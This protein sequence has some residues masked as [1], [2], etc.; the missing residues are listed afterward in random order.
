M[1]RSLPGGREMLDDC[2]QSNIT[3]RLHVLAAEACRLGY[4]AHL[5]RQLTST[6]DD[7][8][9]RMY[10]DEAVVSPVRVKVAR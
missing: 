7:V 5:Q 4:S 9:V 2:I 10:Q 3:M 8:Q 1:L 6:L